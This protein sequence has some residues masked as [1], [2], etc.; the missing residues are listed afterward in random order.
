MRSDSRIA[1]FALAL[2]LA[3]AAAP[4]TPVFINGKPLG[5]AQTINGV[6]AISL[7]DLGNAVGG[8]MRVQG[9]FLAISPRDPASG[10]PTG[11]R[12]HKPFVI[13]K[14]LDKATPLLYWQGKPFVS[15]TN[16]AKLLGGNFT[17]P[18]APRAGQPFQLN[19]APN[20]TSALTVNP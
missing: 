18:P 13:T 9:N 6:P 15:L 14:E 16:V 7:E 17:A 4:V 8:T 2:I 10:L 3:A 19:F 5:N 20:P 12:M 1:L 11:K